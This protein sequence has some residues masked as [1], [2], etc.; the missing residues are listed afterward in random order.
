VP[1]LIA[2]TVQ[3]IFQARDFGI[4]LVLSAQFLA[5]ATSSI[6]AGLP[7][8]LL[9]LYSIVSFFNVSPSYVA[10]EGCGSDYRFQ[11]PL[12]VFVAVWL[13]VLA[14]LILI[15]VSR[16]RKGLVDIVGFNFVALNTLYSVVAHQCFKFLHCSGSADAGFVFTGG[17]ASANV[18]ILPDGTTVTEAV[19]MRCASI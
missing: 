19:F 16:R 12:V 9:Q 8:W 4:W 7:D 10:F 6:A 5:T 13:L 14:Q 1:S 15:Y 2:D 3:A 18:T 17:V 11:T